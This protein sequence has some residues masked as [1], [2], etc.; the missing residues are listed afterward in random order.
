LRIGK[1][2]FQLLEHEQR[3][4]GGVNTEQDFVVRIVLAAK[5]CE[6]L[7]GLWIEAEDRLEITDGGQEAR[8]A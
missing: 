8:S 3:R 4:V 7:I 5:A 2:V 6:V 1:V